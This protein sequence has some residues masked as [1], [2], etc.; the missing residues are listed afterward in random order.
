[1]LAATSHRY[2]ALTNHRTDAVALAKQCVQRL[3]GHQVLGRQTGYEV[4]RDVTR[5]HT[6]GRL[7]DGPQAP[8]HHDFATFG[9]VQVLCNLCGR[10]PLFEMQQLVAGGAAAALDDA[11]DAERGLGVDRTGHAGLRDPRAAGAVP[12]EQA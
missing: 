2:L 3:A 9:D 1:H 8:E 7:V 10:S 12:L 6:A 4:R 11:G 5:L